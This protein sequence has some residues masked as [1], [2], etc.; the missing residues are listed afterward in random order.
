MEFIRIQK[1]DQTKNEPKVE[2]I[3][4]LYLATC[5]HVLTEVKLPGQ[6][7][8]LIDPLAITIIERNKSLSKSINF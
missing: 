1:L 3:C 8:Q 6:K 2:K 5:W 7:P 4:E